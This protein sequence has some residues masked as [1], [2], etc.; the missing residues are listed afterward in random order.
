MHLTVRL[1]SYHTVAI[2]GLYTWPGFDPVH[3]NVIIDGGSETDFNT[4]T[5]V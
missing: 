3:D 1:D 5:N 2:T 4:R